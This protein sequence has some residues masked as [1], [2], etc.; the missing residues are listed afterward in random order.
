MLKTSLH[1]AA[2]KGKEVAAKDNAI[3]KLAGSQ[4]SD[5]QKIAV[6]IGNTCQVAEVSKAEDVTASFLSTTKFC[7]PACASSKF[8][9]YKGLVHMLM[10]RDVNENASTLCIIAGRDDAAVEVCLGS[11]VS[12]ML[13]C[14]ELKDR[15]NQLGFD[16]IGIVA[17][18]DEPAAS[19]YTEAMAQLMSIK[20]DSFLLMVCN[21]SGDPDTWE[22]NSESNPGGFVMVDIFSRNKNRRKHMDYKVFPI[23]RVGVTI[24]DQAESVISKALEKFLLD[25]KSTQGSSKMAFFRKWASPP[26]GFCFWHAVL[27]GL[28]ES[29]R[30]VS[31]HQNGFPVNHRREKHESQAAK[32]LMVACAGSENADTMF[33]NGY[34]ELQQVSGIAQQLNLAI[35]VTVDDEASASKAQP[36]FI[37]SYIYNIFNSNILMSKLMVFCLNQLFMQRGA[38][39]KYIYINCTIL[40]IGSPYVF[41]N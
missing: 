23:D 38:R 25:D 26:D 37:Y 12:S 31:R 34:V 22:F 27:A 6:E 7:G 2:A 10:G 3:K 36:L 1:E 32:N 4:S 24:Q 14:P 28:D 11:D 33:K 18:D 41:G 13:S 40:C 39:K 21:S 20:D 19:K 30:S 5:L 8:F 15:W 29:Y 17:R 35:R 16:S 9:V